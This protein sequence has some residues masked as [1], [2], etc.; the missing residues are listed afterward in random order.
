MIVYGMWILTK[1]EYSDES[2]YFHS[3]ATAINEQK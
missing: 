3:Y 1:I 2:L